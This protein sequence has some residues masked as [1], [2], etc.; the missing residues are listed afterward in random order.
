MTK[1][2]KYNEKGC[3]E[4]RN[5]VREDP[6]LLIIKLK[7]FL[8]TLEKDGGFNGRTCSGLLK[9][10]LNVSVSSLKIGHFQ[11]R[12]VLMLTPV[13]KSHFHSIDTKR[14]VLKL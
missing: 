8:E 11:N 13:R 6:R 10:K 3:V 5:L 4:G 9:S 14:T 1:L 7:D 2:V 12:R